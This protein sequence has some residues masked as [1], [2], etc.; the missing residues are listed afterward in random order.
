MQFTISLVLPFPED[1]GLKMNTYHE[2]YLRDERKRLLD[3]APSEEFVKEFVKAYLLKVEKNKYG[4][5]VP[6]VWMTGIKIPLDSAGY[7]LG[8][9][10][11][12]MSLATVFISFK[13]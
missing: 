10:F 4:D 5:F 1:E 11:T 8:I 2:K 3:A 7:T 13:A 12:I 6:G 9:F